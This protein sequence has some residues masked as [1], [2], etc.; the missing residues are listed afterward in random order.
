MSGDEKQWCSAGECY[1]MKKSIEKNE[2]EQEELRADLREISRDLKDAT[3]AMNQQSAISVEQTTRLSSL[4]T[5]FEKYEAHNSRVHEKLFENQTD[6]AN[7]MTTIQV[8]LGKKI[9][10]ADAIKYVLFIFACFYFGGWI[11]D[12]IKAS[13]M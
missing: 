13:A 2:R 7:T 12:V 8:A 3:K 1:A 9:S 10:S 6:V 11:V 4:S 5:N